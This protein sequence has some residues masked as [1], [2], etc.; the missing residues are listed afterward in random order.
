MRQWLL[1]GVSLATLFTTTAAW[2]ADVPLAARQAMP[3]AVQPLWAG[4]YLGL[5]AGGHWSRDRWT[6]DGTQP[7]GDFGPFDLHPRGFSGGELVGANVQHGNFVW[8]P[9]LDV[10]WLT[11][12]GTFDATPFADHDIDS[13]ESR[14]RWNAHARVRFGYATGEFLP[15]IAGGA[16]FSNKNHVP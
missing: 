11:G 2:A 12:S 6:S 8:G 4:V 15:F 14:P 3:A 16:A 9:E 10:G 13:V 7:A 5:F 1:A